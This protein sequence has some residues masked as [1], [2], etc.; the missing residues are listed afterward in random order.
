MII[1]AKVPRTYDYSLGYENF[2]KQDLIKRNQYLSEIEERSKDANLIFIQG[3]EGAGKT[4][5]CQEFLKR[6][7][8]NCCS[9][10]FRAG[11]KSDF[12]I[13]YFLDNIVYQLAFIL[14]IDEN[15]V[16]VSQR[17]YRQLISRLRRFSKDKKF[18]FIID[19]LTKEKTSLL[20]DLSELFYLGTSNFCYVISINKSKNFTKDLKLEVT[21]SEKINVLGFSTLE[22]KSYLNLKELDIFQ[23][24]KI[25]SLTKG[26]PSRLSLF[27]R[28]LVQGED[29]DELLDNSNN[30]KDWIQV[31]FERIDFNNNIIKKIFS[32]VALSPNILTLFDLKY[33]LNEDDNI[34]K[35][36][37]NEHDILFIDDNECVSFLSQIYKDYFSKELIKQKEFVESSLMYLLNK[38]DDFGKKIEIL[39]IMSNSNKWI[40]LDKQIDDNFLL[41]SFLST[42]DLNTVNN[43]IGL[44]NNASTKLEKQNKLIDISLKGSFINYLKN[45]D[46]LFSEVNTKLSFAD[47]NGALEVANMSLINVERLRLYCIIAKNQ[48]RKLGLIDSTLV[49]DINNLFNICDFTNTG[50]MV[51]DIFSDMIHIDSSIVLKILDNE[52]FRNYD[53]NL[54][55]L[56][57]A[58]LSLMSLNNEIENEKRDSL[59]ESIE[60]FQNSSSRKITR[61]LSYILSDYPLQKIVKDI[62]K[63][64]DSIEKIKIIRLYLENLRGY[65]LG[66]EDLLAK[67]FDVLVSSDGNKFLDIEI[68]ILLSSKIDV[69][70]ESEIKRDL[71]R[72]LRSIENSV[73]KVSLTIHKTQYE[74]NIF[75]LEKYDSPERAYKILEKLIKEINGQQDFLIKAEA[76]SLIYNVLKTNK[77]RQIAKLEKYNKELLDAVIN[78][79][80]KRTANQYLVFRKVIKN[81][82]QVDF[83]YAWEISNL[84]N[85]VINR[86]RIKMDIFENYL[87]YN[88]TKNVNIHLL[89][90]SLK[91]IIED[92]LKEIAVIL[93]LEKFAEEKEITKS[94]VDMLYGIYR[95]STSTLNST[96]GEGVYQNVLILKILKNGKTQDQN[97][98][99]NVKKSLDDDLQKISDDWSRLAI[100]NQICV[101]IADFDIS[102]A[103]KLYNN[104]VRN[105]KDNIF[106]S[107]MFC[108]S[109]YYNLEFFIYSFEAVLLKCE[110]YSS[111]LKS[112]INAIVKIPS[113]DIRIIFFSKISFLLYNKG[114]I[115]GAQEVFDKNIS[116]LIVKKNNIQSDNSAIYCLLYLFNESSAKEIINNLSRSKA[117]DVYFDISMFFLTKNNPFKKYDSQ[118]DKYA[119]P[120]FT[121][122]SKSIRLIKNLN[123]DFYIFKSIEQVVN[124][125]KRKEVVFEPK[126]LEYLKSEIKYIIDNKLPD[127]DNIK[128]SGYKILCN[129]FL[130]KFQNQNCTITLK[131]INELVDN[132]SDRIF[133]KAHLISYI[134][135]TERKSFFDDIIND[136]KSIEVNY[137]FIDRIK[138]ISK[139]M[140]SQNRQ[141]WTKILK[142]SL[143]L[144]NNISD[145]YEAFT[146]QK[147]LIDTLYKID[148]K[149]CKE[150][151]E[152]IDIS[153]ENYTKNKLLK[154]HMSRL[155][156][157]KKIYNN[158][159]IKEQEITNDKNILYA[160]NESLVLLN[161]GKIPAKKLS[162][163]ER[164]FLSAY[165][166]PIDSSL[167]FFIFYLT[168]LVKKN[169]SNKEQIYIQQ[170]I[171]SIFNNTSLNFEFLSRLHSINLESY[172]FSLELK[173]DENFIIIDIGERA[174]ALKFISSWLIS[175]IED[176]DEIIIIDPYFDVGDIEIIKF[177]YDLN[178]NIRFKI[179]T[180]KILIRF[181][182]EEKWKELSSLDIP[183]CDFVSVYKEDK[184]TPFHERYILSKDKKSGIKLGSSLNFLGIKK[185]TD[186][187]YLKRDQH[188]D[189][190]VSIVNRFLHNRERE[191]QGQ[192]IFY[193]GCQ[194]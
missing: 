68:L 37:I 78:E 182:I 30:Y 102:Y 191:I 119:E 12:S 180:N 112:I 176:N 28:K 113:N 164:Y 61:A 141:E 175:E 192:R 88:D 22:I 110:T 152:T 62:D 56:I 154:K 65:E 147:N 184:T 58:K 39:S 6:N 21:K 53:S 121:E 115:K 57:I 9:V 117:D 69:L 97:K 165:R 145:K 173:E 8:K 177:I 105:R 190:Y 100:V 111:E 38:I 129:M 72:K 86:D 96:S 7:D 64:S 54:N 48:K 89:Q 31:D 126:Q 155:D 42:G 60:K 101:D 133:V 41:K 174:K 91:D 156:L 106:N 90:T 79:L 19:G 46:E 167:V 188:E 10:I 45:N 171:K 92:F 181:E 116:N 49:E 99:L 2:D 24:E 120:S 5:I 178:N 169:Y 128:H 118:E 34:I 33:I 150:L 29:I 159:D 135:S 108:K 67:T 125:L 3:D 162:L 35:S 15:S 94:N 73:S 107:E 148:E 44:S 131:E 20:N 189:I 161:S 109:Y 66:L 27:K 81:I 138:D 76:L 74:L 149:L 23:E 50:D 158:T 43:I 122:V 153:S 123:T 132:I 51:Y 11:N 1:E 166:T 85:N 163:L 114:D 84:I 59:S 16:E 95:F 83:Q 71:I 139:I 104:A 40:E 82:C 36:Y 130:L 75:M 187:T 160:I 137:E 136:L 52:E 124:Y 127:R 157:A 80:L 134:K 70:S 17:F 193:E 26:L 13:N 170:L 98:Y 172:S 151:I 25:Y 140:Y 14:G 183:I 179:L 32:L 77:N 186:M 63:Q 168:N 55:E 87:H 146:Y 18:Y 103:K 194:F 143:T 144:S 47:Y 4:I 93:I 142:E 185:M